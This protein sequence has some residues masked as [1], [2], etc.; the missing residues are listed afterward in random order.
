MPR[1]DRGDGTDVD[2]GARLCRPKRTAA[3]S[4]DASPDARQGPQLRRH[5]H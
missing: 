3:G 5:P 4:V 1:T 2:R